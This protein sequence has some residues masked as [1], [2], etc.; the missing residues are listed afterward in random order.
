ME[1]RGQTNYIR[2]ENTF[3]VNGK[4]EYFAKNS[5]HL[6]PNRNPFRIFLVKLITHWT[7]DKTILLLII[8][9]SLCLGFK[10]YID[11][12]NETLKN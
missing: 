7:F 4:Y 8:V 5:L 12:N 2:D 6:L 1:L 11:V 10:D 9:N 3:F